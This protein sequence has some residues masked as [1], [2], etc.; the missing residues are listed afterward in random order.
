M[1]EKDVKYVNDLLKTTFKKVEVVG[2]NKRF[3]KETKYVPD[4]IIKADEKNYIVEVNGIYWHGLI[5]NNY[6]DESEWP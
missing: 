5:L 3:D 2:V 1:F 4:I 6:K